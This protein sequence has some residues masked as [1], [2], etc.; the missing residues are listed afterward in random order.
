MPFNTSA[1]LLQSSVSN[2]KNTHIHLRE[3]LPTTLRRV[4]ANIFTLQNATPGE[5]PFL[6]ILRQEA[7]RSQGIQQGLNTMQLGWRL[8]A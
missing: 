2:M 4:S 1:R 5:Y 8:V 3:H 6:R 7:T